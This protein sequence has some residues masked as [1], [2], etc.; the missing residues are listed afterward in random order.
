M[1]TRRLAGS[2][3][4]KHLSIARR[5]YDATEHLGPVLAAA[6]YAA[7]HK[8]WRK[9]DHAARAV[10]IRTIWPP[11]TLDDSTAKQRKAAEAG[12]RGKS[13]APKG[14]EHRKASYLR[15]NDSYRLTAR[16]SRQLVRQ[17]RRQ[18]FAAA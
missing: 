10:D 3:R 12:A 2:R 15:A 16:Q 4:N 9:P 1:N 18:A 17:Q 7:G 14:Y 13:A 6:L 8:P 11:L 5:S